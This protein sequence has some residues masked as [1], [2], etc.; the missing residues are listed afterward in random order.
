MQVTYN[1]HPL[2]YFS[3]DQ[4][5]GDTNGQGIGDIWFVVSPA[6]DAIKG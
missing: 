6:G 2:Y 3:G 4:A 5:P 1:G